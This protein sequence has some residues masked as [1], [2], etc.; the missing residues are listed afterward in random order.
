MDEATRRRLD[1]I[2]RQFYDRHAGDFSA[3]R[4]RPWR[5]WAP[6]LDSLELPKGGSRLRALDA[7]CGNGR[8]ARTLAARLE[9]DGHR[10]D[11]LG[12]DRS[13]GLLALAAASCRRLGG[14]YRFVA[15]D[16]LEDSAV[17][18]QRPHWHLIALFGVLHHLPGFVNRQTLLRQLALSLEPGG[19]LLVSTWRFDRSPRLMG[20]TLSAPQV[21]S[22]D[23]KQLE[24]GDHI[25]R[26]G[27]GDADSAMRYCHLIGEQELH[28]LLDGLPLEITADLEDDGRDANL[29]RYLSL[30]RR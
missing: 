10:L 25:L 15:S 12:V 4:S 20:R 28:A 7:G 22:I 13:L 29:N 5:G 23:S 19:H 30:S 21:P 9:R 1:R 11:Y 2:N 24:P 14:R 16:L 27:S 3:R 26:W 6:L 18:L 17:V 8:F